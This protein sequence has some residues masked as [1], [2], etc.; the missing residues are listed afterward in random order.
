MKRWIA[1]LLLCLSV[2]LSGCGAAVREDGTQIR[3]Y[4]A[5]SSDTLSGPAIGFETEQMKSV[6]VD[7]VLR[8]LLRGPYDT[9]DFYRTFPDGTALQSW[10]LEDGALK[11]DLSEAFGR[12]SGIT[13]MKAEYCIVLTLT[14]VEGVETV[15]IT[16]GG[17]A[18]PGGASDVLSASDVLL[19]GETEDPVIFGSQLYFPLEDGTGLG[20]E[21]REFEAGTLEVLDQAN[22]VLG[23]LA[24]GPKQES[25]IPFLNGAG[26]MEAV[27]V[28]G[29]VCTVD[30]D[31]T[32]MECICAS[33]E[34]FDLY[35]YAVVDSLVELEG[36]SA[37]AFRLD[38]QPIESWDSEYTAV[39]EF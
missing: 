12:L 34:T 31:N 24:Q 21:Y 25:L 10:S 11:L 15:A 26:W 2:L 6:T 20:L 18:L 23:Q 8:R 27:D 32:T 36:V 5:V 1:W 3:F 13:M 30:M 19:R 37:V 22:A 9:A 28:T 14:Q 7:E 16:A 4:Y 29:G 35:L 33:V 38:G 39:Y 17:Q